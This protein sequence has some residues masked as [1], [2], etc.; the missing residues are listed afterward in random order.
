[1]IGVDAAAARGAVL[2]TGANGF[3]GSE[4]CR[5]L[6][7]Q[8]RRFVPAVRR[9]GGEAIGGQRPRVVGEIGAATDWSAVVAAVDTVVHLASRVHVMNESSIDTLPLYRQVNTLATLN[10][11]RQAAAAGVRRFVFVSTV[12]V[13]GEGGPAPYRESDAP[14][15]AGPYAISKG[16]AEQGLRELAASSGIEVVIVR[17]PLVYGAGVKGNFLSMMGWV[18]RGLP[19]PFGAIDNRRSLVALPNLVDFLLACATHPAAANQ[20]FLISDGD[21]LSTT[22]LLRRMAIALGK[23]SRLLPL[24]ASLLSA[25]ASLLGQG[26]LARRLFGS[27]RV[28]ASKARRVLGWTPPLCVDQGLRLAA[29]DFLARR[30]GGRR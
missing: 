11:A 5:A 20:T 27:L 21:D 17:P 6:A 30:S 29:A 7:A 22:E 4:L 23:P 12:K 18:D 19:M 9:A 2:V 25:G 24:P 16:E 15:P 28:D 10:L 8:G 13:N 3:V 14:C 1:V 26:D